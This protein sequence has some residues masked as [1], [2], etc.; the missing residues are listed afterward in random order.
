MPTTGEKY[1]SSQQLAYFKK[2]LED[3]RHEIVSNAEHLIDTMRDETNSIPDENDRATKE[4]E[5]AVK[6]RE[7]DRERRLLYKIEAALARVE[8]KEF[9]N[10]SEC[11][12]PIGLKRL[13]ARPVA[14]FCFECKNLRE[15]FEKRGGVFVD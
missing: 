4:S 12:D 11:G 2:M 5:F 6:L 3:M 1:M 7:Q 10:C 9:G 13:L 8:S 15:R 14:I